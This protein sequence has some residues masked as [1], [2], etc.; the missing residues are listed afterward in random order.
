MFESSKVGK[1]IKLDSIVATPMP[2]DHSLP[3]AHGFVLETSKG[4]IANTADLRF[5][6]R[7]KKDTENFVKKCAESSIDILLCEGTRIDKPPHMTEFD[8]ED[9]IA[10]IVR[11][12][13]KLVICG[14][15]I[16]DLDRLQSFYLAAKETGRY[17]AIDPKQA[18]LLKLFAESENLRGLYPS[19]NDNHIMVYMPKGEWGLIDKDLDH[20]TRKLLN[21][22]YQVWAREFLDYDN[23]VD[24]RDVRGEARRNNAVL[25]RL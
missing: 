25:G 20:F 9:K 1:E 7:R 21:E 19:P 4:M 22:D 12:T 14:Y 16:R 15:P 5:H 11:R 17:L 3:G 24:Y 13:N 6:G 23:R 8:I 18:Y 10:E 2:V